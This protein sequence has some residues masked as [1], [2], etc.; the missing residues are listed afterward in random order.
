MG[1][2][3]GLGLSAGLAL[4]LLILPAA[5]AFGDVSSG[6]LHAGVEPDPWHLTIT[7]GSGHAVLSE[8][9]GLGTGP[10]GTLGFSTATGWFHATRVISGGMQGGAY[11]AQL[12][13]TDPAR[14]IQVRLEP[15]REGVI[16]LTA[17][18]T[19]STVGV[20]AMGIGFDSRAGE[21]YLG[22]GERSNA[23]DQRGNAV[24][25]YV[26]DGPYAPADRALIGA[27][28]PPQG[29]HPRDDAT[30]FP[31]PWLLSTAGYGVL[32]GNDET[33]YFR[34][35]TRTP[36]PGASRLRRRTSAFASSRARR[37]PMP[38]AG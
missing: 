2:R 27:V 3:R 7:D 1:F 37:R 15:D 38:S 25:D 31:V 26:S 18:V 6:Q 8:N 24:E 20:T 14:G 28:I 30:Y 23:V 5:S 13:T 16:G 12:E 32:L 9:R 34:L 35:G 11:V 22:F 36:P 4:A 21:R 17:S 29:W 19:G 10:T 33:S